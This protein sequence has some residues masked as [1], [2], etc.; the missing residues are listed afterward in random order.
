MNKLEQNC[1]IQIVLR[2]QYTQFCYQFNFRKELKIRNNV[3]QKMVEEYFMGM[4]SSAFF[5][6]NIKQAIVISCGDYGELREIEG[7]EGFQ[8][9]PE[10]DE[11][12]SLV[13][14]GLRRLKF[15]KSEITMLNNPVYQ[16]I[17]IAIDKV[18]AQ[19][20]TNYREGLNTLLYV[21]YAG[22][23]MMD[24][25]TYC[26][27]NGPRMY[28]LEKML[29]TL[30][31]ADGSYLVA[32]FDCCREKV[33]QQAMRGLKADTEGLEHDGDEWIGQPK[34][35]QENI[36]ITYGCQPSAGV[37]QK[38][39]IA[40]TYFRYLRKSAKVFPDGKKYLVLPGCLNFFQNVDGKCEHN[41]KTAKPLMLEW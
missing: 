35:S 5:K 8:D 23:G 13:Y 10:V 16:E 30:A 18:S 4:P 15:A 28:P 40:N 21:Y 20:Y 1:T 9:I 32:V 41:I 6:V 26:V 31:K 19:I 24:N 22:H 12:A 17:K 33:E 34:D 29:R 25:C 3:S 2:I 11:D 38:S 14:A 37:P 27:L 7:K 36:I 39:T